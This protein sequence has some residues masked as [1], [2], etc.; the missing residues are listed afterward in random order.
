MSGFGQ[1]FAGVEWP[2]VAL[3]AGIV[4][5]EELRQVPPGATVLRAVLGLPFEPVTSGPG[6]R[7]V[8]LWPP[9]TTT[10]IVPPASPAGDSD[11]SRTAADRWAVVGRY[12]AVFRLLA[13]VSLLLLVLGVP[14][15]AAWLGGVGLL[16]TLGLTMAVAGLAAFLA[17]RVTGRAGVPS[18]RRRWP[19]LGLLSPFT[20]PRVAEVVLELVMRGRAAPAVAAVL[21]DPG[22]FRAWVR[23]R[24]YDALQNGDGDAELDEVLSAAERRALVESVPEPVVAGEGYCARCGAT[25][26]GPA[27]ACARCGVGLR[28]VGR[29]GD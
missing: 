19:C 15:A 10:I 28:A 17:Y 29:L 22:A 2:I 8:G 5:W 14:L 4:L 21:M 16:V 9:L 12:L 27:G 13:G 1:V 24:A 23:P 26:R 20:A 25:Y 11:S 3:L 7:L 6:R 18:G